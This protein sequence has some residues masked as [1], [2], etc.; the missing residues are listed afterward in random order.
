MNI[1]GGAASQGTTGYGAMGP[2]GSFWG[3]GSHQ[4]SGA[5]GAGGHS[6][7]SWGSISNG[8]GTA[9]VVVIEY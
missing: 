4:Y 5:Y 7:N 2:G 8:D 3:S 6:Y 1:T 9:G